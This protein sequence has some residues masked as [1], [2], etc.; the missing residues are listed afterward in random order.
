[1]SAIL[2]ALL[3]ALFLFSISAFAQTDATVEFF[4]PQGTIKTVRQVSARF[5]EPM[6][7]FGD[8]RI[9][10]P[11]DISCPEAGKGRWA[12][13]RNWVY[14]FDRDLSAGV[15]CSFSTRRDLKALSG[16]PVTNRAFS[17]STGGPA[18][19]KSRPHDGDERIDEEQIFLL[20]LDAAA[21][22]ESIIANAYC[23]VG[24]V[25]EKVGIKIIAGK[26]R[27]QLLRA[28]YMKDDPRIIALQCRQRF[29][30]A[31][32][33]KIVWGKG[34]SSLSGIATESDQVLVFKS[35]LPFTAKFSCDREK[36]DA[37]CIPMLPMR[38]AFSAPVRWDVA[39]K[40]RM[41][42][43]GGSS[44]RS[45][46]DNG[47]YVEDEDGEE[48]GEG[49]SEDTG[50]NGAPEY[51]WTVSFRGPF[52][53]SS[54][55]TIDMPKDFRDDSGRQLSNRDKYPLTVKTDAYP[56]LAKF[57]SRFGIIELKGNAALPV[58]LR[59]LESEVPARMLQVDDEKR[60]ASSKV[61]EGIL[62]GA[63]KLGGAVASAL[64]DS[65]KEK[66]DEMVQGLKGRLRKL[67]MNKEEKVI[68]WLRTV[69]GAGRQRSVLKGA[70]GVKE[71]G[72]PKP[73]GEKAFEVVG[74]PL[75]E[76]GVYVVEMESRIL[77]SS[78]LEAGGKTLQKKPI[79]VPTVALITNLAVHFKHGRESS[80]VWVTTLDKAKPVGDA[81]ITI[82]DC[83]GKQIW[84]GT[85]D[86]Q[87]IAR[88]KK[89]LPDHGELPSCRHT[90]DSDNYYDYPQLKGLEGARGGLFVFAKK[91][92]DMSFVHSSWKEGIESWRYGLPSGSY[93]GPVIAHTVF[94]RTLI[95]AGE[96]VHMK[97]FIRKHTM[98]GFDFL[99]ERE[100]PDKLVIE[101]SGSE[102]KYEFPLKWRDRW[103][104]E[105]DWKIPED[106]YLGQYSVAMTSSKKNDADDKRRRYV[107]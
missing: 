82:R 18:I 16:Q 83:T 78:L 98:A 107:S 23:S 27:E 12:D 77:G 51:V 87:G 33:I 103:M 20:T 6:V 32:E 24:G 7:P 8:P 58:T 38:L 50:K 39:R 29:P 105:S 5:S 48:S 68:E 41:K 73:G 95:H 76:P 92:A 37:N 75:K 30:A 53:E 40:I 35:R 106:A 71:F 97:H 91:A 25:N 3:A 81:S 55:F 4:S 15:R 104:A 52:P 101:H 22:E 102:K 79:Y 28:S 11:F 43:P 70:E 42:G 47:K 45:I 36:K 34:I 26:E 88:I 49:I 85:T 90:P 56:P 60:G 93:R 31:V 69:A 44:Y 9:S 99:P 61:K 100:L 17:F 14:D 54:S 72:V 84:S 1:M 13:S 63:A 80:L 74:I 57:S 89:Q 67:R 10:D 66:P 64:P 19:I 21:S 86:A 94:D 59:N 2:S 96:T 65:V 62:D 46:P